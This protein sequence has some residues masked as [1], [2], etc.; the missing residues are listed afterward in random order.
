MA[1]LQHIFATALDPAGAPTGIGHHHV[2]TATDEHWYST[3]T[4][5]V[6]DWHRAPKVSSGTGAPATTPLR[7][8][9]IYIDD[10]SALEVSYIAVHTVDA[11]GWQLSDAKPVSTNFAEYTFTSAGA[12]IQTI[13]LDV[14]KKVHRIQ[15][16]QTNLEAVGLDDLVIQIPSSTELNEVNA[17]SDVSYKIILHC[18]WA[19]GSSG[20]LDALTSIGIRVGAA[21][22]TY[23]GSFAHAT[24]STTTYALIPSESWALNDVAS[25]LT[26]NA[27]LVDADVWY[28]DLSRDAA[29]QA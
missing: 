4:T 9:D 13:T 7:V 14:T 22:T 18:D 8:G 19:S 26:I 11:T 25:T 20:A 23:T 10:T 29:A 16:D 3:G 5:N 17:I 1:D 2:N 6:D 15:F 24:H 21:G 27:S 12:G 28:L